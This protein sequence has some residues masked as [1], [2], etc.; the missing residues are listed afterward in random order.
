[1]LRLNPEPDPRLQTCLHAPVGVEWDV[2]AEE[3]DRGEIS[4]A[5]EDTD[6]DDAE[7]DR[8]I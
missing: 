8:P 7:A 2:E 1:M 4:T 5:D 6:L 3:T